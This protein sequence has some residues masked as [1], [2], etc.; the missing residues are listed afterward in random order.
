[1]GLDLGEFKSVA[2]LCAHDTPQARFA[3]VHSDPAN[4]RKPMEAERSAVVDFEAY[5]VAGWVA[6][7]CVK[8]GFACIIADPVETWSGRRRKRR[9]REAGEVMRR[10]G[11]SIWMKSPEAMQA[12]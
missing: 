5:T 2:F 9:A 10:E 8:P 4:L 3:T 11:P 7:V 1:M 12:D 6:D